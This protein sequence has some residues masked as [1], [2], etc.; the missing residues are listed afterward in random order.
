MCMNPAPS[1]RSKSLYCD[2][3]LAN[4]A[5]ENTQMLVKGTHKDRKRK[6]KACKGS[7]AEWKT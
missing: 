2:V 4:L 3:S 7:N 5:G 1:V 6:G